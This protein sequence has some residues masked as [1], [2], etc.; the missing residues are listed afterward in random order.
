MTNYIDAISLNYSMFSVPNL[1]GGAFMP[2]GSALYTGSIF[3]MPFMPMTFP[4]MPT[5]PNF[6]LFNL[7]LFNF[8]TPSVTGV[9][10][11]SGTQS[12]ETSSVSESAPASGSINTRMVQKA[13]SYVGIVNSSSEGNRLFSPAGYQN[14]GWYKKYGRWGWC[15][16]FAVYCAKATLGSKYPKDMI[17][18]SPASLAGKAK[19]HGAYLEVPSSDK[20]SW[21]VNNIRPGDIIYMKGN[22]DSGKHIAVVESVDANGNVKAISGNSGGKVKNMKYNINTSGIYGFISLQKLAA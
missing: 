15:C 7:P 19:K 5:L 8:K 10:N 18:S 9:A 14:T 6:M 1:Y 21:L 11:T 12:S 4:A 20:N 13:K 3:S 22:G 16:D 2:S 17:T